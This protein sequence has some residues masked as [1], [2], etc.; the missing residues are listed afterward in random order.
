MA[1]RPPRD[2]DDIWSEVMDQV[3]DALTEADLGTGPTREALL[4]G[5]REA[6]E[7]MGGPIEVDI[8]VMTAAEDSDPTVSVVEGGRAEADPRT[9]GEKPDLRVADPQADGATD[10]VEAA[11]PM[12][13]RPVLTQV[14]MLR[15]ARHTARSEIIPGL[16]KAGWIQVAGGGGVH[17]AWQ[18]LYQGR[19]PRLY[20]IGCTQG[21]MDVTLDGDQVER[22]VAGQAIDVEG[23]LVRVCA[24][25]EGSGRGGYA[26]I[27][28]PEGEE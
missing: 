13:V 16:G 14:K 17:A 18:T 7:A 10:E 5:V 27:S 22:L 11:D 2:G 23:C 19:V 24:V 3:A 20:R 28:G 21:S 8:E 1:K 9:P 6:L 25:D 26:W 4:D 12:R 15:T